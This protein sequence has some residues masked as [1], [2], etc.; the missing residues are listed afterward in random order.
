MDEH[1]DDLESTVDTDASEEIDAFPATGDELD[2]DDEGEADEEAEEEP[3]D[4]DKTEL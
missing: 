3:L 2:A 4:D 1:D